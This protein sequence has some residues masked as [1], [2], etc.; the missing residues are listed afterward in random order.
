MEFPRVFLHPAIYTTQIHN[1]R[2]PNWQ[3]CKKWSKVSKNYIVC[4]FQTPILYLNIGISWKFSFR[5][6]FRRFSVAILIV[7]RQII[8]ILWWS[9][10]YLKEKLHFYNH[11]Y[12]NDLTISF[13]LTIIWFSFSHIAWHSLFVFGNFQKYD[14][15]STFLFRTKNSQKRILSGK[16]SWASP[17]KSSKFSSIG[18]VQLNLWTQS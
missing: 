2:S 1:R 3:N 18:G 7:F 14:A 6:K 10:I 12:K 9:D 15:C 11:F 16:V 8:L 13:E 17:L 4:N 5:T